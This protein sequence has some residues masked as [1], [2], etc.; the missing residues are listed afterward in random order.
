MAHDEARPGSVERV[1]ERLMTRGAASAWLVRLILVLSVLAIYRQTLG[2]GFI[3]L[4]DPAYVMANPWVQQGLSWDGVRW[5]FTSFH[6]AIWS[7]VTWLSLMLDVEIAGA[8]PRTFHATNFLLHT[9]SSLLLFQL[10]DRATRARWK[11]AWVAALFAVHPLHVESVAWISER[12]DVLSGLFWFLT[13]LLWLRW[14]ERPG[15]LRYTFVIGSFTLGLLSKPMLVTL[16]LVLLLFDR[17]PLGRYR[18]RTLWSLV[19]EKLPLLGLTLMSSVVTLIA[20]IAG[21]AVASLDAHPLGVRLTNAIVSYAIYLQQTF[22]P[23]R[24]AVLYPLPRGEV[25]LASWLLAALVLSA[26]CILVAICWRS[27]PYLAVGWLWYLG[28]LVPT[29]GIVQFGLQAR[30]DRFTYLPLVGVFI[31]LAWG[32]PDLLERLGLLKDNGR[33]STRFEPGYRLL[34]AGASGTVVAAAWLAYWQC[35]YWRDPILLFERTIEVTGQNLLARASLAASYHQRN[36]PGD[37]ERSLIQYAEVIRLDP[38]S[39]GAR[40]GLADALMQLGRVEE[41]IAL[42]SEV[43]QVKPRARGA[44]CN[45]CV[46]LSRVGRLSEAEKRCVEALRIESQAGCA[47]HNLGRLY[48]QQ[49]RVLDAER[50]LDAAVRIEPLDT[51]FRLSLGAELMR[52]KRFEEAIVQF[53]EVLRLDPSNQAARSYLDGIRQQPEARP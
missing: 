28:T 39:V 44:L 50:Q 24:L 32:V 12:K 25:P 47:H 3:T 52:Q 53:D 26:V 6:V 36:G 14:V 19:W 11:S 27:R 46:A 7:P 1:M 33:P 2:F 16:P 17:W 8:A 38:G 48:L 51:D 43:V 22:W 23:T 9:A 4:D 40:N 45:L 42:W 21:H 35:G 13:M 31:M 49:E 34:L 15:M 20:Q 10:L 37:L 30:A 5:A 29:I 41:S 18:G